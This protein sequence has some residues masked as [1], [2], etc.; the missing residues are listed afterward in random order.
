VR[1][2]PDDEVVNDDVHPA[3]VGAEIIEVEDPFCLD[4][5]SPQAGERVLTLV[6]VTA[7]A[8]QYLLA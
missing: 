7:V 6:G 1:A 8:R 5:R 2:P 4:H 3:S